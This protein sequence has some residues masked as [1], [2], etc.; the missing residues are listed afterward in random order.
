MR[1]VVTSGTGTSAAISNIEVCGKTGTS[2][3]PGGKDHSLFIGFAP[4]D[5]PEI[6][7]CSIMENAG[8]GATYAAPATK[9]VIEKYFAL[10]Q[11]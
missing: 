5:N 8:F 7:V 10:K 9:A 2:E 11:Y 4:Y 3:N 1:N 6:A